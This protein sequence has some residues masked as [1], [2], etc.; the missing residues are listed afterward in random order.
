[1]LGGVV[2]VRE[3]ALTVWR[4]IAGQRARVAAWCC[5]AAGWA[6]GV[7][8]NGGWRWGVGRCQWAMCAGGRRRWRL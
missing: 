8:P 6:W 5:L 1:M 7:C 2:A 4:C 3:G